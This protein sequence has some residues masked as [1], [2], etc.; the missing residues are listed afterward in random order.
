[1]KSLCLFLALVCCSLLSAQ[2]TGGS[3]DGDDEDETDQC[4]HD[5]AERE[6]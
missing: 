3:S 6:P 2:Y 5:V 1:M 4:S